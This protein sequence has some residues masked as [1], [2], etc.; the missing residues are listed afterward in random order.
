[1][2]AR[3]WRKTVQ[4]AGDIPTGILH[5]LPPLL[6]NHFNRLALFRTNSDL[7]PPRPSNL[8]I[9]R[10]LLEVSHTGNIRIWVLAKHLE[11]SSDTEYYCSSCYLLSDPF[12][13]TLGGYLCV[14]SLDNSWLQGS[15]I[16]GFGFNVDCSGYVGWVRA[17][18]KEV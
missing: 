3:I 17:L 2:W 9:R 1:M 10:S 18:C 16:G 5:H 12:S 11:V 15:A 7:T 6:Y 8:K 4:N 14:G 13:H